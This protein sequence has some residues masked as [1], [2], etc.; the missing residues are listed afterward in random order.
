MIAIYDDNEISI[1]G[2][3]DLAFTENVGARFKAYN[4]HVVEDVDG[5]DFNALRKA[6]EEAKVLLISHP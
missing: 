3:T 6:I 1:E 2:G 4:W 5:H